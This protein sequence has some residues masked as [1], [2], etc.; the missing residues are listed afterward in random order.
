MATL[1]ETF[2]AL[3]CTV[4]ALAVVMVVFRPIVEVLFSWLME[5]VGRNG[6]LAGT[7]NAETLKLLLL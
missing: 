6:F 7:G 5:L 4:V 3:D 2:L 1:V